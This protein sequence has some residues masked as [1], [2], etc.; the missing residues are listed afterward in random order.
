MEETILVVEDSPETLELLRRVLEK[1]G[2]KTILANDGE[3]GFN[4]AKQYLPHLIV[5]DRLL[6][7]M[8]GLQ[9]CKK[10]K[11]MQPAKDIP[12]IF[13]SVLDSE[14]DIIDGL[15]AGADDY[16]KKPFNPDEFL[17]RVERILHRCYNKSK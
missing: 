3:K 7:K 12:I 6:P 2:Y 13:L 1:E 9:I 8:N 16:I 4:Y 15:K 10:L 5:L 17:A 14:K 11:E